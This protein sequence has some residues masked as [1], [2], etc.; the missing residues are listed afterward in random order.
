MV[1]K[2]C[3][4][5]RRLG[6]KLFL[7]GEKCL[8]PKCLMI[9]RAYPP[10]QKRR[11]RPTPLSEYGQALREKQKL[12]NWYNLK[13][14]Q[15]KNYVKKILEKR[16]RVKDASSLLIKILES[17]LDNVVF[18][19]GFANSRDQ[20]RQLVSHGHFLVNGKSINI[21]SYLVKKGDTI[22]LKAQKTKKAIFQNLKNLLKKYKVPNWLAL[23]IEKL[24]GKVIGEPSLEEAVPPVEISAIFEFYSR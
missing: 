3:K 8:S 1:K 6:V 20:A 16:G 22:S 14:R 7:K 9:K 21:P 10:G 15:F 18:R 5:C 11:R 24:E 17:R 13:E 2:K 12:K 4:I 19:L 23:D